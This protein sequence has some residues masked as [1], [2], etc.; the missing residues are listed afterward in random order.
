MLYVLHDVVCWMH[1]GNRGECLYEATYSILLCGEKGPWAQKP[2][3]ETMATLMSEAL[4][5]AY[6]QHEQDSQV[7]YFLP[8]T[9]Q[10]NER[11]VI[12]H[13]P[14]CQKCHDTV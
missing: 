7:T 14:H 5:H 10:S 11:R 9:T 2:H 3:K 13:T 1:T 6:H 8:R 12:Q 4:D